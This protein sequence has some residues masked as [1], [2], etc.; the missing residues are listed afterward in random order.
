MGDSQCYFE[1]ALRE[2]VPE[3]R[4]SEDERIRKEIIDYL[5]FVGKGDGEPDNG[6]DVTDFCKP[7]DPGIAQCVADHWWEML[8]DK[9]PDKSLEEAIRLWVAGVF[10]AYTFPDTTV[11]TLREIVEKTFIAGAQWQKAQMLKEAVE[12]Q[13]YGSDGEHWIESEIYENLKGKEGDK[14]RIIVLKAEEE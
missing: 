4:E 2:L 3:L 7:I 12:G 13:I 9:E 11:K 14:V 6:V 1:F 5:G 8:G 10:L